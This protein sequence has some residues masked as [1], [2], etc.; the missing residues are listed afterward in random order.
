MEPQVVT[1]NAERH[2]DDSAH[3]VHEEQAYQALSAHQNPTI[4]IDEG[5]KWEK[6]IRWQFLTFNNDLLP[7]LITA[8]NDFQQTENIKAL[9][10]CEE[11][12]IFGTLVDMIARIMHEVNLQP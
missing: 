11:Q 12:G 8:L 10:L 3:K 5:E 7:D 9:S 1:E 6:E 4:N 2:L